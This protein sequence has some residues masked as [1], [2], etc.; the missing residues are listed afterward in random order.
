[1]TETERLEKYQKAE[2]LLVEGLGLIRQRREDL[3]KRISPASSDLRKQLTS[4]SPE[5]AELKK[6][7]AELQQSSKAVNEALQKLLASPN[8]ITQPKV[9]AGVDDRAGATEMIKTIHGGGAFN[10]FEREL[11]SLPASEQKEESEVLKQVKQAH[12]TGQ[13]TKEDLL[14]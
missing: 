10:V 4:D 3:E 12:K 2:K 8:T 5:V 6:Q 13:L 9:P 11:R 7:L 14:M 1:M